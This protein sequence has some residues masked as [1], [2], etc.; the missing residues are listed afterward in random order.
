MDVAGAVSVALIRWG[1]AHPRNSQHAPWAQCPPAQVAARAQANECAIMQVAGAVSVALIR[2][3]ERVCKVVRMR[4]E[5]HGSQQAQALLAPLLE[6][7]AVELTL[8][9]LK[10][11]RQV[12]Y[13]IIIHPP[14]W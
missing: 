12:S 1:G 13:P 11:L 3:A 2:W 14:S 10:E 5:L 8:S 6:R 9:H 7:Q 4:H